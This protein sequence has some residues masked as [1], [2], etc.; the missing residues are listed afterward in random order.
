MCCT[1]MRLLHIAHF[2]RCAFNMARICQ[3]SRLYI[4]FLIRDLHLRG[5]FFLHALVLFTASALA[6]IVWDL[7]QHI[8]HILLEWYVLFGWQSDF[9]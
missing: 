3:V 7:N 4:H 8:L 5:C 1:F 2:P 6:L 9:A